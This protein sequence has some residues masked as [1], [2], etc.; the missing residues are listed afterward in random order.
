MKIGRGCSVEL[1]CYYIYI[2]LYVGT[3]FEINTA[4]I[5]TDAKIILWILPIKQ[6]SYTALE[7]KSPLRIGG[8]YNCHNGFQRNLIRI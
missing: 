6:Y 8:S 2:S 3:Y 5:L 4:D 1:P 7:K